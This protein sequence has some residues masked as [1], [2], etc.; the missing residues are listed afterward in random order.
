MLES[1]LGFVLGLGGLGLVTAF[2]WCGAKTEETPDRLWVATGLL[3][4]SCY[5]YHSVYQ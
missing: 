3:S 5:S 2:T 1:G 4:K